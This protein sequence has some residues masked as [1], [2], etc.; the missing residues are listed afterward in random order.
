M[1]VLIAVIS[2]AGC[3]SSLYRPLDSAERSGYST[4]SLGGAEWRVTFQ[5]S[6]GVNPYILHDFV[7][8]RA[9]E[10]T[11]ES[12]HRYFVILRDTDFAR[13]ADNRARRAIASDS[14]LIASGGGLSGTMTIRR[15][16]TT[17]TYPEGFQNDGIVNL[18]IRL[19]DDPNLQV[20]NSPAFDAKSLVRTL[21]AQR[22]LP[23]AP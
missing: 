7:M 1:L 19:T 18:V 10:L 16:S 9:A 22:G 15:T 5:A 17:T 3:A 4:K 11:L 20:G 2:C 21:R 8:L 6:A 12:G 23:P 14:K 13:I